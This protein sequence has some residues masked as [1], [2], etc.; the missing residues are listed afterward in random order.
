MTQAHPIHAVSG[1]LLESPVW[2]TTEQCL[3]LIDIAACELIRYVPEGETVTRWPLP[4]NPGAIALADKG[5]LVIALRTGIFH[6]DTTTAAL[7]L[8]APPPYDPATTRFNDGRVDRLGRFWIGSIYEPR[9]RAEAS[10]YRLDTDGTLRRIFE[11]FTTAN[12]LAFSPDGRTGYCA[13]TPSRKVWAFDLDPATGDASE[14][15]VHIDLQALN[16]DGRPDGATVDA[17]G[18]YWLALI[19]AGRVARFDPR[20][21]LVQQIDLPVR[22]PTCP[23]FGGPALQTLYVTNLRIGRQPDQLAASPDAGTLVGAEL[24]IAGLPEALVDLHA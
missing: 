14:R 22:W 20:G 9:D 18:C 21:N 24:E 6:F 23:C 11:G 13:D 16:I 7:T 8:I 5:D 3:Y 12:G 19:D 1:Q 15:R 17:E 4:S 10:I 2:S